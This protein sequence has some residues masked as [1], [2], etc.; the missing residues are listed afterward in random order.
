[1]PKIEEDTAVLSAIV[2]AFSLAIIEVC[3]TLEHQ[4]SLP[5][6]PTAFAG[7][8]KLRAVNLPDDPSNKIQKSILVSI[9]NGLVGK[10]LAPFH[11]PE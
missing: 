8:M 3:Q 11:I 9:A 1:M 5:V 2:D 4:K 10:P 6:A 7:E